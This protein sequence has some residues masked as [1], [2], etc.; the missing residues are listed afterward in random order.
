MSSTMIVSIDPRAGRCPVRQ[1]IRSPAWTR[2]SAAATRV[3][4]LTWPARVMAMSGTRTT[5]HMSLAA[6]RGVEPAPARDQDDAEVDV[7]DQADEVRVLLDHVGVEH[8]HARADLA[9]DRVGVADQAPGQRLHDACHQGS[10]VAVRGRRPR[11][12][13]AVEFEGD[14]RMPRSSSSRRVARGPGLL[15][16]E[17]VLAG[18]EQPGGIGMR[19]R[20]GVSLAVVMWRFR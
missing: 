7:L 16:P 1:R 2:L 18:L 6:R 8:D 20:S 10:R 15:D 11:R 9:G 4:T 12:S 19:I 3:A 13:R 14:P 17:H 5:E